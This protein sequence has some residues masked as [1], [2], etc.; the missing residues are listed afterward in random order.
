MLSTQFIKSRFRVWLESRDQ[1]IFT[2]SGIPIGITLDNLWSKSVDQSAKNIPRYDL[3]FRPEKVDEETLCGTAC[4][5]LLLLLLS[6]SLLLLL[7]LLYH[8]YYN[9][10]LKRGSSLPSEPNYW[11]GQN[12][13]HAN[14]KFA[15]Y[16]KCGEVAYSCPKVVVIAKFI[17]TYPSPKP[18]FCL[19]WKLSVN[20]GL[21]EG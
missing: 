16:A 19:K 14:V 20:V 9:F 8:Y 5:K 15:A 21:G 2:V 11:K 4:S 1:H 17:R 10:D 7:L 3:A 12:H 6:S 18:T 13:F